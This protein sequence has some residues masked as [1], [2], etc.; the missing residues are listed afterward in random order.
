M[1]AP[2]SGGPGHDDSLVG[3]FGFIALVLSITG[4]Y[5]VMAYSV[6]QRINE[7]GIRLAIGAQP[8]DVLRLVLRKGL[9]ITG[10]GMAIGVGLALSA[11]GLLSGFL[12]DVSAVDPLIFATV[13]GLLLSVAVMACLVPARKAMRVDPMTAL[14]YE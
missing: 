3:L 8:G 10:I 14:R 12:H 6:S 13:I 2:F 1:A 4:V 7:F 11:G 5:G 9:M